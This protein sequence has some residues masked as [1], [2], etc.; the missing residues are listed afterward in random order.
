MSH[1]INITRIKTLYDALKDLKDQVVFVGGATVSLYADRAA[2]EVRETQDVD[3]VIQIGSR[4]GYHE[5]EKQLWKLGFQN[6]IDSKILCRYLLSDL[7]VDV[8]P[9]DEKILGFS[10]RWYAKGFET[11]IEKTIDDQ[12]KIKIFTPPYFIASKIEAFKGRGNNDG[13]MSHDFE[14]IVF[15][16]ENRSS[17]WKEMDT[18]DLLLKKYL[19]DEFTNFKNIPYI[20]EWIGAH[21]SSYSPPSVYFIMEDMEQFLKS[22]SSFTI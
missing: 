13:R 3:I 17:I 4:L 16:L 5:I 8:M 18:S 22:N 19:M 21:A 20:E 14:D 7:K 2:P 10:N 15:I 6:D 9:I 12:Y 1:E 11:A